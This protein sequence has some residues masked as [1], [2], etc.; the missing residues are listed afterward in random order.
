MENKFNERIVVYTREH[1]DHLRTLRPRDNPWLLER[2]IVCSRNLVARKQRL[3]GSSGQDDASSAQ[4][5]SNTHADAE[6]GTFDQQLCQVPWDLVI[7]D[8][9][10]H[11]RRHAPRKKQAP[12]LAYELV[13]QLTTKGL[14][15]LT[16]TPMQL[17]DYELFSLFA[18]LDPTVFPTYEDFRTYTVTIGS[19]INAAIHALQRWADLN[20]QERAQA[21]TACSVLLSARR[22]TPPHT[23]PATLPAPSA[24]TP[25]VTRVYTALRFCSQPE[26]AAPAPR[27][28][29][30]R[31]NSSV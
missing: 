5:T 9:A 31:Y 15:L 26:A 14:L 3:R 7:V 11:V 1:L 8:E 4:R 24:P 23:W 17:D 6:D 28:A 29:P 25:V 10:H 16:A 22:D 12:T 30:R 18:L 2:T 20:E 19:K 21:V 27:H 13:E